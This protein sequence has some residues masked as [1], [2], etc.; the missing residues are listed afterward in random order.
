MKKSPI[1]M[2]EQV[3]NNMI[4]EAVTRV[5]PSGMSHL[6]FT[7]CFEKFLDTKEKSA[8]TILLQLEI[9][10]REIFCPSVVG[11]L[12]DQ[13]LEARTL[14]QH[15]IPTAWEGTRRVASR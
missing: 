9:N 3:A 13:W 6:E 4:N 14:L 2:G 10:D 12:F 8:R 5:I 7:K 1:E 11:E 15:T